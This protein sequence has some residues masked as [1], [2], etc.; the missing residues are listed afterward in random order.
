MTRKIYAF[1]T[2]AFW[3]VLPCFLA[4]GVVGLF[5]I[6]SFWYWAIGIASLAFIWC[7]LDRV[8]LRLYRGC[9]DRSG[10]WH[11]L[12]YGYAKPVLR[13]AMSAAEYEWYMNW[14]VFGVPLRI[15]RDRRRKKD[16][17]TFHHW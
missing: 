5:F 15:F 4:G 14:V 17:S 16:P 6:K 11:M 10:M 7:L 12:K 1:I 8:H 9:L 13:P 2:S 3:T